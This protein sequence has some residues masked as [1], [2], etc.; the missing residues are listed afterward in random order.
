VPAVKKLSL[1]DGV[2]RR[3]HAAAAFVKP[4]LL[5]LRSARYRVDGRSSP[6][7][8]IGDRT[9]VAD[10]AGEVCLS[11]RG[12]RLRRIDA[13]KAWL[14]GRAGFSTAWRRIGVFVD[15]VSDHGTPDGDWNADLRD[16][17]F[18]PGRTLAFCSRHPDTI[19]VP[20]RAFHFSG[21]YRADRAAG[22]VAPRFAE[23]DAVIAW[24]GSPS[25][26]GVPD[27][28]TLDPADPRLIQRVRMC[29]MLNQAHHAESLRVDAGIVRGRGM[30]AA[31]AG[32]YEAAGILRAPLDER[33][34]CGRRFAIDIDGNA[35]AFS[36]LF[37]RLLYGCCVIKVASPLGF[38]QWYYDRLVPW[39]HYVPVRADLSDL[40]D[41][42]RWVEANPED[43]ERIAVAGQKLA[44]GMDFD[45]ERRLAIERIAAAATPS[46]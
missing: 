3:L 21:G 38:R 18:R 16:W 34:W 26:H 2:S 8:W 11:K 10:S 31:L 23:R 5:S 17:A 32:R 35:N 4:Q 41:A 42:A 43:A 44:Q 14:R 25:G 7:I 45:A 24:R 13:D 36:N 37:R 12:G 29:L 1:P 40:L 22:S 30:D 9:G 15:L 28:D 39:V 46:A 27:A 33:S 20:D 6:W 19:L